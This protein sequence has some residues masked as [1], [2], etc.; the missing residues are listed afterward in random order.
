[1]KMKPILGACL[2][3][4]VFA[5]CSKDDFSAIENTQDKLNVITS[6]DALSR[7]PQLNENGSG[8]FNSGDK[9]TLFFS[10]TDGQKFIKGFEYTHGKEHHWIDV[11]I[12]A[13]NKQARIAASYP[14][15]SAA[16]K[17]AASAYKWNVLT[18]RPTND[19][20]LAAPVTATVNS[21]DPIELN[22]AHA[23]HKFQVNLKGDSQL[24]SG[25]TITCKDFKPEAVI[26]LLEG[27]ATGASGSLASQKVTGK[28][29]A[30][31]LPAQAVEKMEVVFHVNGQDHSFKLS[32]CTVNDRPLTELKSGMKLELNVTVD[33]GGFTITGQN[34]SAWGEQGSANGN[35]I[36]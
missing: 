27:K 17:E 30:F 2:A 1:M 22:F 4:M 8:H 13:G 23:L 10:S 28:T 26:N 6:I 11:Q 14:T 15:I 33:K 36:L 31:I 9:Y 16:S 12:P 18:S 32:E 3:A 7:A 24:L 20:L 21:T 34:I 35:I 5:A 29:A 19:L 25:A